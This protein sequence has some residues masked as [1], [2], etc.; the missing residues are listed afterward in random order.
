M[1]GAEFDF[2]GA[3]L[4]ALGSGALYWRD[5]ALLVISDM[6]LCRSARFA[7]RGGMLL[8][9][10]EVADTLMRLDGAL[11]ESGARTVICLGDSFDDDNADEI[12]ERDAIWLARLMAGRRWIWIAGNHDP[13]PVALGGTHRG[14]ITIGGL[15]F[16]HIARP[17]G[18]AE[19]SGHYHPKL[20]LGGQSRPCF[21]TDGQRLVM[22]AFGTYT[23]GMDAG[24]PALR[25]LFGPRAWAILTGR[26]VLSVPV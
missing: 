22:P 6:H 26:R 15:T 21:V 14:E 9:P 20:R 17:G 11:E 5:E 1:T 10:Y 23:G 4:T 7:R 12:G 19:V 3:R 18:R 13:G 2:A 24:D 16:C 8:P 25:G